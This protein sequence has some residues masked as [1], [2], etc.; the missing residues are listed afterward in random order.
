MVWL[1]GRKEVELELRRRGGLL[2]IKSNLKPSLHERGLPEPRISASSP[3]IERRTSC[4]AWIER[5]PHHMS[6]T[7]IH[8]CSCSGNQ[9]GTHQADSLSIQSVERW[10]SKLEGEEKRPLRHDSRRGSQK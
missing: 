9:I 10:R 7:Q 6:L 1:V 5:N 4:E 3:E 8:M 2:Q